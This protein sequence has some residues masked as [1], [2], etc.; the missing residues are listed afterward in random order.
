MGFKRRLPQ[1]PGRTHH[2]PE[3]SEDEVTEVVT[4]L[5]ADAPDLLDVLRRRVKQFH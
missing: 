5:T 1:D 3:F 4:A 2:P